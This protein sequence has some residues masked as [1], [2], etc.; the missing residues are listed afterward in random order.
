MGRPSGAKTEQ[1]VEY[2]YDYRCAEY[3]Y[4]GKGI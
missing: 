3:E 1:P 4:E 2:E